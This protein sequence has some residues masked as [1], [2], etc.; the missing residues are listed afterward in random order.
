M[1]ATKTRYFACCI[2]NCAVVPMLYGTV[3]VTKEKCWLFRPLR[4]LE[5]KSQVLEI[6]VE[7][8][9][10]TWRVYVERVLRGV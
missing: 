1:L 3:N 7:G 9:L 10:V 4:P 8:I 5:V 6:P 2:I